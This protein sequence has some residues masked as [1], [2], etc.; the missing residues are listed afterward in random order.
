VGRVQFVQ[1][2][3]TYERVAAH[4]DDDMHVRSRILRTTAVKASCRVVSRKE[5]TKSHNANDCG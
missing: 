2:A 4:D 3:S 5:E 1:D